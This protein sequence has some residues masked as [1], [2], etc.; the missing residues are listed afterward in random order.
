MLICDAE[1]NYQ[2]ARS[3]VLF[4]NGV[5][6]LTSFFFFPRSRCLRAMCDFCATEDAFAFLSSS[7]LGARVDV[8][9]VDLPCAGRASGSGSYEAGACN[10]VVIRCEGEKRERDGA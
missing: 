3:P 6:G 8:E 4:H 7:P 2:F 1:A 5:R 9:R 10:S